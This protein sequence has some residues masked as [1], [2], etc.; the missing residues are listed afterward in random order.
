MISLSTAL[1]GSR[2]RAEIFGTDTTMAAAT[3]AGT[4]AVVA[5]RW[6]CSVLFVNDDLAD[7]EL[8]CSFDLRARRAFPRLKAAAIGA[9]DGALVARRFASGRA[10][11]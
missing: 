11:A 8:W 7:G 2:T 5:R 4:T 6:C 1:L 10:D 3:G 9:V